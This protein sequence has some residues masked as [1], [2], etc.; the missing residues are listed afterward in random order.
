M[1][2]RTPMF[3]ALMGTLALAACTPTD[4][5]TGN[6]RTRTGEGAAIGAIGGALLGVAMG[7]DAEARRRGAVIGAAV[8]AGA[9][10]AIG[11]NLDQQAAELRS[12]MDGRIQIINQGDYLIVRMP[13][14]ILF[15]VD[16]ATVSA[17]LRS[18]LGALANSLQRYPNSTVEVIGHT[19]NTGSASYN[20]DLS[21]R[22]ASAV[23]TI[24]IGNGIS[25]NRIRAIGRGEDQ[26]I[27]SNQTV[28]GRA[29]NR[30]V[31]IYIRPN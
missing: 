26:P 20:L 4:V 28:S 14:D 29:Q 16:S 8:G 23:A 30:R 22:R 5:D 3:A 1:T 27:A 13:E 10:A 7:D 18:D 9:G 17:G 24:L 2:L 21:Q 31:D 15:A 12:S 6:P 11:Y 25:S 19:D